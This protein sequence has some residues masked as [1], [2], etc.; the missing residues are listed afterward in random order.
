M[1]VNK[2]IKNIFSISLAV[3]CFYTPIK[4]KIMEEKPAIWFDKTMGLRYNLT[5]LVKG[6][7]YCYGPKQG[8]YL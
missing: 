3:V 2:N 6:A 8:D 4:C 1:E 7:A 5:L